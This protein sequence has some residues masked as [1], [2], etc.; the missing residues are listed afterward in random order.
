MLSQRQGGAECVSAYASRGLH[1]SEK[2]VQN[3]SAFKLE[4][5]A[6]KWAVTEKFKEYLIYSKFSVITDHNPLCYLETANLGAV[7]QW[8]MSRLSEFDFEVYYKPG[9]QNTNTHVLSMIPSGEEHE[10]EDSAKD[11]IKMNSD[12]GQPPKSS[13]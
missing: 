10:Q 7:E 5:L 4:L 12:Y 2:N 8:W 6:L 13:R 9:R 11:F 1:G 3:Y